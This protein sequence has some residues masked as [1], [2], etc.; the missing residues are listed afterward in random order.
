M[1]S[2]RP[3]VSFCSDKKVWEAAPSMIIIFLSSL[4]LA[5]SGAMMPGPL[6]TYTIGQAL[7]SGPFAGLIIITGHALLELVLVILIFMGFDT[8]LQSD[9]AQIGISIVGGLLLV[10][11]GSQMIFGSIRN[12]V[13]IELDKKDTGAR[14]MVFAGIMVS[15]A[16][17]YF[18]LWWAVVGLGFLL[19]AYKSFGLAGV[20]VF[21][22]G[23]ILAD[24][25]WYGSISL[26]VGKTRR[27]IRE[28]P[29]RFLIALLGA[30][31]IYFGGSFFYNALPLL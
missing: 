6:L 23:H 25:F 13:K 4:A 27:F 3:T 20:A 30:V 16:N 26:V 1:W 14:N 22:M 29:Y 21:Y 7:N 11:M 15:A 18:F 2:I 9:G 28:N 31:L 8:I 12:K 17:P 10:Y 19:Q 24:F 5:F